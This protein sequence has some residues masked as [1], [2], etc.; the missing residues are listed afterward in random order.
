MFWEEKTISVCRLEPD[1]IFFLS[2]T[3]YLNVAHKPTSS[4]SSTAVITV[5]WNRLPIS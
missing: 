1:P 4:S 3:I 2:K 5:D